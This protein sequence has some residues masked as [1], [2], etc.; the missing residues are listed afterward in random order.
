MLKLHAG[1]SKKVGLPGFSS[2]SASCTIEAELDSALLNDTEGFQLVVQRAYQSCEQ[3][4][5][6]QIARLTVQEIPAPRTVD[7]AQDISA[8]PQHTNGPQT[9]SQGPSRASQPATQPTPEITE[10][11]TSPAISGARVTAT[12]STRIPAAQFSNQ[13]SPRPGAVPIFRDQGQCLALQHAQ[14]GI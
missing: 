7:H 14:R 8:Q 4:V 1:I 3:A 9:R 13:P 12:G 5:Q 11:R 6:D 2:A 10:V